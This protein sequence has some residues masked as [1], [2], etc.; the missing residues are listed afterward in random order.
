MTSRFVAY[1]RVST[2]RQGSSGLGLEAQQEAVQRHI[3][4]HSGELAGQ[5]VEIES[6]ARN[7]RPQLWAAID[8]CRREKASLVIAK[9]DRLARNVHFI[10][11]L[12]DSGV[13]FVA[14]DA[15]HANRLMLHL[16]AAFAEHEREQISLR[17]REAL[18]AAK[19]RGVVLGSFA[20]ILAER[21]K[22]EADGFARSVWP[23]LVELENRGYT[24]L[25]VMA[26]QLNAM[27]LRTSSGHTWRPMSVSRV[28]RRAA[29]I[30][31]EEGLLPAPPT[32]EER[33][34]PYICC[35]VAA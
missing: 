31:A 17:T 35:A 21:N 32:G 11:G 9:L 15:P 20:K 30:A 29:K 25:R 26:D 23:T 14:V 33:T 19:S 2:S 1:F 12:M 4:E 7:D 22:T 10:A 3:R 8:L 6:G 13:D 28:R 27:G 34:T 24:G 5:F 18:A 16:L